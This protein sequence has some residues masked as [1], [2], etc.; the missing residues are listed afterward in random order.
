VTAPDARASQRNAQQEQV[1][2]AYKVAHPAKTQQSQT[3]GY[4]NKLVMLARPDQ[5]AKAQIAGGDG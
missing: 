4:F 3:K 5:D 2:S 1:Q